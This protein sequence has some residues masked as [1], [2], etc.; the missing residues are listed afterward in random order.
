MEQ[1]ARLLPSIVVF[2]SFEKEAP[3]DEK[4]SVRR[5]FVLPPLTPGDIG[6]RRQLLLPVLHAPHTADEAAVLP[7]LQ[8]RRKNGRLH[9]RL[10]RMLSHDHLWSL[11]SQAVVPDCSKILFLCFVSAFILPS[12]YEDAVGNILNPGRFITAWCVRNLFK[13]PR[14]NS[15]MIALLS[16]FLKERTIGRRK[17]FCV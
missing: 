11:E 16:P 17:P 4:C 7:L 6:Y 2:R 10:W 8:D 14:A 12:M 5:S 13:G 3:C 9:S 1:E 15:P